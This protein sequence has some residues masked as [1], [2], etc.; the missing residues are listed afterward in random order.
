ML[1]AQA[2]PNRQLVPYGKVEAVRDART[3]LSTVSELGSEGHSQAVQLP[4]QGSAARRAAL[5]GV[6]APTWRLLCP[7]GCTSR[8]RAW[9]R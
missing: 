1:T 8:A 6:G 4:A 7:Y 9:V 3:R 5:P 2:A